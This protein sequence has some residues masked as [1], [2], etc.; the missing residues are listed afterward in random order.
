MK[1]QTISTLGEGE[2]CLN[3]SCHHNMFWDK[4][5]LPKGAHPTDASLESKNCMSLLSRDLTLE[6]IGEAWGV[7]RE[8]IRQIERDAM[9]KLLKEGLNPGKLTFLKELGFDKDLLKR[10]H[11]ELVSKKY[12]T[13]R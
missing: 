5:K 1:C 7:T 2:G 10:R 12:K 4:L 8:R 11:D 9:I 3:T 13:G 6:E